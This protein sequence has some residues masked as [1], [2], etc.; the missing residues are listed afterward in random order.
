MSALQSLS[1]NIPLYLQD[2][3]PKA[4]ETP[5]PPE[6]QI[7]QRLQECLKNF[8]ENQEQTFLHLHSAESPFA[9]RAVEFCK[10]GEGGV[11]IYAVEKKTKDR[12]GS[13]KCIRL[14]VNLFS[15]KKAARIQNRAIRDL[16]SVSREFLHLTK[17]Q[18]F[19]G[20]CK[21]IHQQVYNY[22]KTS[23]KDRDCN[24][25][26]EVFFVEW[27]EV[28]L[29]QV[30]SGTS[31]FPLLSQQR[32]FFLEKLLE[33]LAELHAKHIVLRDLKLENL[34]IRIQEKGSFRSYQKYS[35][36]FVDA[37]T[38]SCNDQPEKIVGTTGFLPPEILAL[39][40]GDRVVARPSWD[41]WSFGWLLFYF[42]NEK[43]PFFDQMVKLEKAIRVIEESDQISFGEKEEQILGL[44]T[45]KEAVPLPNLQNHWEVLMTRL[46]CIDPEKRFS[47]RDA[48]TFFRRATKI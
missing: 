24:E 6:G 31:P 47:A 42:I 17:L 18:E 13:H 48:L 3:S 4:K 11:D 12:S 5:F 25:P 1:K 35:P 20:F 21:I 14:A 38:I 30:L 16:E 27:L 40:K 7:I 10:T 46:L 39:A 2:Y 32:A 26:R 19:E 36:V 37:E 15:L 23:K 29:F 28:D 33:N 8:M 34:M 44:L 45:G 43:S 22:I 41:M 9:V